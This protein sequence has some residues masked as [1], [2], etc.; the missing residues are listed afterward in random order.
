M[1]IVETTHGKVQGERMGGHTAFRGIPFAAPPV[2]PL[3]FRAPQPAAAWSG[4]RDATQWGNAAR[5]SSHPIPGFAASGPQDED[6]L[7]LNIFTPAADDHRRPAMFWIH[8]GGFTHG[9]ASE[10][11]Y[12]GGPLAERG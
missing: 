2:G 6:C 8:G 7:Y 1:S 3:R 10:A 9:A 5:Q 12:D 4:V 11:L